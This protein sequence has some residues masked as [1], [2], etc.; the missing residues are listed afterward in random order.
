MIIFRN[1]DDGKKQLISKVPVKLNN[2]EGFI[3]MYKE[4]SVTELT[5]ETYT[6]IFLE[7]KEV[8]ILIC[9]ELECDDQKDLFIR[10]ATR[11]RDK[12]RYVYVFQE[13]P[14]GQHLIKFLDIKPTDKFPF[15][16]IL[17]FK[18]KHIIKYK[19]NNEHYFKEFVFDKIIRKKSEPSK[20]G[21]K[22]RLG[23]MRKKY[24]NGSYSY[25]FVNG[26]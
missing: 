12:F 2:L 20:I 25:S 10:F 26:R 18:D 7:S 11:N 9:K 1:F 22:E 21:L 23:Q 4:K 17:E 5:S 24:N 14:I 16:R 3:R 13:S 6:R 8:M 19:G 15:I